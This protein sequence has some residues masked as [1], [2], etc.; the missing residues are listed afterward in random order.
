MVYFN[1]TN[2]TR[3][4]IFPFFILS[5]LCAFAPL[6]D[7]FVVFILFYLFSPLTFALSRL[8]GI[9]FLSSFLAPI[10][11]QSYLF[12]IYHCFSLSFAPSR[13]CGIICSFYSLLSLFPLTFAPLRDKFFYHPSHPLSQ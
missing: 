7:K 11:I 13:L 1:T 4:N 12:L 10:P 5:F 2:D 6:R 3:N 8:C 9:I